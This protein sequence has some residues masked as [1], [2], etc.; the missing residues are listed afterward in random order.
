MDEVLVL[1][2][3]LTMRKDGFAIA[4]EHY[5]WIPSHAFFRSFEPEEYANTKVDFKRPLMDLGCGDGVFAAML[6]EGT[7]PLIL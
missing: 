1:N 5:Y 3:G 2:G 7:H 4:S 6:Q